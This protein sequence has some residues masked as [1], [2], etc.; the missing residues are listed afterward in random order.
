MQKKRYKLPTKSNDSKD[1]DDDDEE[2]EE[3]GRE[4]ESKVRKPIFCDCSFRVIRFAAIGSYYVS[5]SHMSSLSLC[6]TSPVTRCHEQ[7]EMGIWCRP[8]TTIHDA[9]RV[10]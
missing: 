2:E 10:Y 4:Y 6:H 3:E 5:H 1:D 7:R 9:H 8:P